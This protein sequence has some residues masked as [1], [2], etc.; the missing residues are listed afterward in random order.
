VSGKIIIPNGAHIWPH[1]LQS[2]KA[3]A[4]FGYTVEFIPACQTDGVAT[5]DVT[6]D[7]LKWEMK[8]PTGKQLSS[9]EKN[10]RR[11]S[12][13]ASNIIFD[14]RRMKQVPDK[15]I[16]RELSAK[17]HYISKIERII[18]INRHGEIID[19]D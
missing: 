7:N 9:I 11:G 6:I 17:L 18:F 19:I 3:L 14:S 4:A 15:A 12:K 16:A 13:Q 10:L 1:E 5:A 8:A 2:A